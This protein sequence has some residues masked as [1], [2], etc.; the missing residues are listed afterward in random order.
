MAEQGGREAGEREQLPRA[1][2]I[3]IIIMIIVVII[4][5]V[6]VIVISIIIRYGRSGSSN[7]WNRNPPT[8]NRAPDS[9]FS[10]NGRLTKLY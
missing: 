6:I 2:P 10:K 4:I 5:V 7:R 9:Q 1:A 3:I 8:P